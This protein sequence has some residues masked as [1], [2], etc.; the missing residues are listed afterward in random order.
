MAG[1]IT[2][3]VD[4]SKAISGIKEDLEEI[5]FALALSLTAGQI[6]ANLYGE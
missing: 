5:P 2:F 3:K 6:A 1:A 4:A